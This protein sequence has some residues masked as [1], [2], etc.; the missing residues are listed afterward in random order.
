MGDDLSFHYKR[1]ER[2]S[3]RGAPE[4]RGPQRGFLR[5]G[6]RPFALVLNLVLIVALFAIYA[7]SQAR[8]AHTADVSGWTV[9]LRAVAAG[10]DV[11]AVIEAAP[12]ASGAERRAAAGERLFVVLR[13]GEAELPL[14]EVLPQ[15]EGSIAIS[16]RLVAAGRP[17]QLSAEVT[18]GGE[19]RTLRR[20][21][22][23]S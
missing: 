11:L 12:A 18:I 14:S 8:A 13:A 23:R 22:D 1:E 7:R 6:R 20:L 4:P 9:T 19:K 10:E 15:G 17:R 3:M 2:L 21:L 16:G 5:G